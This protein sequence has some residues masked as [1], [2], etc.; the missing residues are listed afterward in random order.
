MYNVH[1]LQELPPVRSQAGPGS[2]ATATSGE[3]KKKKRKKRSSGSEKQSG[4]NQSRIKSYDY[5]AW[6][7]FDVV[8]D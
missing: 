5:K 3:K 4:A 6:D 8:S 2:S 1:I 7:K